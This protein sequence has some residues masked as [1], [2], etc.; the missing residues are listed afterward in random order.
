[1][2]KIKNPVETK[3]KPPLKPPLKNKNKKKPPIKEAVC[4][5]NDR[6]KFYWTKNLV[7]KLSRNIKVIGQILFKTTQ[8]MTQYFGLSIGLSKFFSHRQLQRKMKLWHKT[9]NQIKN[10]AQ[11]FYFFS[12]KKKWKKEKKNKQEP[13]HG[14]LG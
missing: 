10:F 12:K 14:S 6:K 2:R 7:Y 4:Y 3:Q 11:A 13:L 9:P 5:Y 8:S 1:M